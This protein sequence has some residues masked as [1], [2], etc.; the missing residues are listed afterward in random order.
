MLDITA[1]QMLPQEES[2]EVGLRACQATCWATDDT[3]DECDTFITD[4]P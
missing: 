1:L 3:K 2:L 4:A